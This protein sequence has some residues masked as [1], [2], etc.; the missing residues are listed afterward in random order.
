MT[1]YRKKIL[2]PML[3]GPAETGRLQKPLLVIIIVRRSA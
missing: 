2:E 1:P 3:L